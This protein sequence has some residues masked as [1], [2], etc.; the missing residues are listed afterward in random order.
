MFTSSNY[1]KLQGTKAKAKAY[2]AKN[3]VLR[4]EYKLR[5]KN[6]SEKSQVKFVSK[7][8]SDRNPN[9][10]PNPNLSRNRLHCIQGRPCCEF[11]YSE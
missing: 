8:T 6:E 9:P 10:N 1:E 4:T 11:L 2:N 3:Y 7:R 5:K